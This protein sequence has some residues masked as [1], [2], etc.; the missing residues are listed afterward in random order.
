[1]MSRCLFFLIG[2]CC[3]CASTEAQDGPALKFRDLPVRT[4]GD[5]EMFVETAGFRGPEGLSRFEIYS[6]L[7]ARQLQFVP[8]GEKYVA[9]IDFT[10]ALYD[11]AGEEVKRQFWTR[12]VSVDDL[13]S[14]KHYASR[15]VV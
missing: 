12:N 10:A 6:L 3:L 14:L 8:E 15:I 1:M 7:D 2:I 4:E 13:K 11:T 9:Q 5:L